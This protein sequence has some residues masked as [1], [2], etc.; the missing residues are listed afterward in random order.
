MVG[1]NDLGDINNL[2]Y[3]L[4]YDSVYRAFPAKVTVEGGGLVVGD[5]R[6]NVTSERERGLDT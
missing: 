3:L 6:I 2:A 4:Q 5:K 1:V